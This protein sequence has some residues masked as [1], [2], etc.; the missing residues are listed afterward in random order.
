M[1]QE[2][3]DDKKPLTLTGGHYEVLAWFTKNNLGD[4]EHS[5]TTRELVKRM[6]PETDLHAD[7]WFMSRCCELHL[8][9][10]LAADTDGVLS[11]D[12]T[13]P[14]SRYY[15]TMRGRRTVMTRVQEATA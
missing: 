14:D 10:Y 3:N 12:R 8:N 4:K 13:P 1:I 11:G 9:G 6:G 5:I 7:Q 2:K 15:L